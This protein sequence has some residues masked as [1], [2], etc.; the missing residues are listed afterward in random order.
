VRAAAI[1]ALLTLA[2]AGC[3]SAADEHSEP[4]VAASCAA[5]VDYAGHRYLGTFTA[6]APVAGAKL[7]S[8]T[9]PPCAD[10]PGVAPG[11]SERVDV[12]ALEDVSTDVALVSGGGVYIREGVEPDA[13]PAELRRLLRAPE[14]V[15]ADEPIAVSGRWLGILGADGHTEL[16]LVPPYDVRL[17]VEQ[18]SASRYERAELTIRVPLDA[19]RPLDR[20]DIRDSLWQQGTIAITARCADG[21]FVAVTVRAEPP[22][23]P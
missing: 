18:S 6:V 16:D 2:V 3:G 9:K 12:F 5:A 1:A 17:Q 11:A 10:M 13:L 8:G 22:P 23:G 4:N 21:R 19:G 20:D 15:A 7:G 14:C